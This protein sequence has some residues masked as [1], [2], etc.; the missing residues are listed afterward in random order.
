MK[1]YIQQRGR[2][3]Y[4]NRRVPK[5][6]RDIEGRGDLK[7]SLNTDSFEEAKAKAA[8]INSKIEKRWNALLASDSTRAAECWQAAHDIAKSYGFAFVGAD[9]LIDPS[10]IKD[11]ANRLDAIEMGRKASHRPTVEALLGTAKQP[12][13]TLSDALE[14]Y[15][16]LTG[17]IQARKSENQVRKWKNPRIKAVR[18]FTKLIERDIPIEEISRE[19]ALDFRD[20]WLD[21]VLNED[22]QPDTANKDIQHLNSIVTRVSQALRLKSIEPF[23][24]LR[25]KPRQNERTPPYSN[26]FIMDRILEKNALESLS[27]EHRMILYMLIETGAR[28]GEI[29]NLRP[30]NIRLKDPIPHI[31]IRSISKREVK[32]RNAERDIPLV[33]ISLWAAKQKPKGFPKLSDKEDSVSG[34]INKFLRNNGLKETPKHRLYSLRSAFQDRMIAVRHPDPSLGQMPERMQ[35]DL[36]GHGIGRPKYGVGCSAKNE[37]IFKQ[38]ESYLKQMAFPLPDWAK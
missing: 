3:Y 13:I 25:L 2:K 15:F 4:Y 38:A 14:R 11:L 27:L 28:P 5:H 33:G 20:W 22:M 37:E 7:I 29:V 12:S 34:N 10:N 36:F 19:M 26:S 21:R 23:K 16:S 8:N 24:G 9:S 30:E 17:E 1:L 35:A 18:N 32:T 6:L 31:Q